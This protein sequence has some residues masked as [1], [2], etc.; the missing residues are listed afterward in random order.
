[1]ND[2]GFVADIMASEGNEK[3]KALLRRLGIVEMSEVCEHD[4]HYY[5]TVNSQPEYVCQKCGKVRRG[6]A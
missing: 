6:N 4:W 5:G 2:P 3:A 1:M